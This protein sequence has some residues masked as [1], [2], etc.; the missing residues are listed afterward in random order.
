MC[1]FYKFVLFFLSIFMDSCLCLCIIMCRF[2]TWYFFNFSLFLS[3]YH[4]INFF[5]LVSNVYIIRPLKRYLDIFDNSDLYLIIIRFF[6][7]YKF[8]F[9][10]N[11]Q[12][13]FYLCFFE[14]FRIRLRNQCA[15]IKTMCHIS[16]ISKSRF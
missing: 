5:N 8:F 11:S 16:Y 3:L 6:L 14:I 1:W 13:D 4:S 12:Q 10:F 7:C 2:I 9:W 15:R